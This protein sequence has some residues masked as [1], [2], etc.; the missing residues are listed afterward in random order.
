MIL[1]IS[2]QIETRIIKN[3]EVT[4]RERKER[5]IESERQTRSSI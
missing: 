4:R 2:R 1:I 3:N 5:S